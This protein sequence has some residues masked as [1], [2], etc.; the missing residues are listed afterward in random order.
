MRTWEQRYYS[1]IDVP[2]YLLRTLQV[3]TPDGQE[4]AV[5][6]MDTQGLFDSKST[7]AENAAIFALSVMTSSV[8]IY[9]IFHNIQEDHLQHLEF[10]TKYGQLAQKESTGKPFQRLVFLVRD[11]NNGTY[12]ADAGRAL[13]QGR[14]EA[15][16]SLRPQLQELRK[17]INDNFSAIDCFLMPVKLTGLQ[18]SRDKAYV[19]AF[20]DGELPEPKSMLQERQEYFNRLYKKEQAWLDEQLEREKR[21]REQEAEKERRK[22]VEF[23]NKMRR[24]RTELE[25]KSKKEKKLYEQQHRE[26]MRTLEME[27]ARVREENSKLTVMMTATAAVAGVAAVALTGGAVGLVAVGGRGRYGVWW[28][29]SGGHFHLCGVWGGVLWKK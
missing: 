8:Q 24:A 4:V 14:L 9:N 13:I 22:Q 2:D 7:V 5:L 21:R 11:S 1:R 27:N 25:K 17:Y 29:G 16:K 3:P 15:K 10:F 26:E 19:E 23:E 28:G 18:E 12:G 20:R 6:F